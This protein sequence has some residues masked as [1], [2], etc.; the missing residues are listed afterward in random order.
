MSSLFQFHDFSCGNRLLQNSKLQ[1][2]MISGSTNYFNVLA[3][4]QG[5]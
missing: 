4:T 1:N 5:L 3:Q 2:S